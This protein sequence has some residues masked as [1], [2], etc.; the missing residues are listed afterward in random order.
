MSF[1]VVDRYLDQYTEE[2]YIGS[3]VEHTIE[4]V[5]LVRTLEQIGTAIHSHM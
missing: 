2:V 3:N 4:N 5:A 1:E